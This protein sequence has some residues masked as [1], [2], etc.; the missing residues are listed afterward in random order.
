MKTKIITQTGNTLN[1]SNAQLASEW[2][3]AVAEHQLL[4]LTL[5]CTP[6]LVAK[7]LSQESC[8]TTVPTLLLMACA[9]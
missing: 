3:A 7:D 4:L 9:R 8:Q 2:E 6:Q 1:F 5:R